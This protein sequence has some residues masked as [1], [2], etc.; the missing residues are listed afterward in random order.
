MKGETLSKPVVSVFCGCLGVTLLLRVCGCLCSL[1]LLSVCWLTFLE[2]IR[3]E[4]FSYSQGTFNP[5]SHGSPGDRLMP[6]G[7]LAHALTG[8][9]Q[10]IFHHVK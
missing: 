2:S 6:P 4:P 8:F 10:G 3:D 5:L 7:L 1:H 9:L